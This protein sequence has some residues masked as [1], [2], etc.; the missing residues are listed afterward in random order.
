MP[1]V[2]LQR[3][4]N[5]QRKKKKKKG[6]VPSSKETSNCVKISWLIRNLLHLDFTRDSISEWRGN[7]E[8]LESVYIE[9]D[10]RFHSMWETIKVDFF[11]FQARSDRWI[12]RWI[13]VKYFYGKYFFEIQRFAISFTVL[14]SGTVP[15]IGTVH[16]QFQGSRCTYNVIWPEKW[17]KDTD[18]CYLIGPRILQ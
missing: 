17:V 16:S 4:G 8:S 3:Y 15:S 1:R 9:W 5:M 10:L 6:R 13:I 11:H 7:G 2:S 12:D 14:F 18:K